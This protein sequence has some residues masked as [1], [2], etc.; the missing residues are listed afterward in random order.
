MRIDVAYPSTNTTSVVVAVAPGASNCS[1]TTTSGLTCSATVT[2]APGATTFTAT[3]FD[4]PDAAGDVLSLG[5]V[6]V[7]PVSGAVTPVAITLAGVI[8]SLHMRFV[9]SAPL[10]G[11]PGTFT[12]ALDGLDAGGS[13]IVAPGP[14]A[15]PITLQSDSSA[16]AFTPTTL[17]APGT[18]VT[19]TYSGA[20]T[21][22]AHLIASTSGVS[23]GARIVTSLALIGASPAPSATATPASGGTATPTPTPTAT[24]T[25]TPG[26]GGSGNLYV[27]N[28]GGTR[29]GVARFAP[30]FSGSSAPNLTIAAG[31][32][33]VAPV[34]VAVDAA[35]DLAA[36]LSS[37]AVDVFPGP[38]GASAPTP[39]VLAAAGTRAGYAAFDPAGNLW[40][41]A[42]G[43][44][45]VEYT[46]PFTSGKTASFT[47]T[48]AA[49]T[50]AYGLA[51]DSS[52]NLYVTNAG[53]SGNVLM[54][55]P[56]YTSAPLVGTLPSGSGAVDL[57]GAALDLGFL[58]VADSNGAAVYSF[59]TPFRATGNVGFF[60]LSAPLPGTSGIAFDAAGT[61][62]L[63][64][65]EQNLIYAY[66]SPFGPGTSPSYSI[67]SGISAPGGLA[68]GR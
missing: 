62:Y 49:L 68:I 56:P 35:G 41:A 44:S 27:A 21:S 33:T 10:L 59:A 9:G 45:I 13:T 48:N 5:S 25:P 51:F 2:V 32:G 30:P 47:L 29:P 53:T 58:Y 64:N 46:P 23:G 40:V 55:A 42:R 60:A 12:L 24:P 36:T 39:I 19:V 20:S 61:L 8:A 6:P 7:P 14:Y 16:F 22:T 31:G 26:S 37:G 52:R 67:A 28:G 4:R 43:G 11:T 54:F 1:G 3:T 38:L 15:A 57:R 50:D 63:G 18:P 17:A 34:G 66:P 65:S